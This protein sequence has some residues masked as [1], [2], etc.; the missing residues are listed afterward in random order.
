MVKIQR[1]QLTIQVRDCKEL[2]IAVTDTLT[3]SVD[4]AIKAK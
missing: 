1:Q 4:I 2:M 3:T